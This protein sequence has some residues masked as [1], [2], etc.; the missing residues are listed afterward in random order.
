MKKLV[1]FSLKSFIGPF[2]ITLIIAMF[3]LI[4]QFFWVYIDDLLGKGLSVWV[5]LELLF[6]VSA[7]LIPLALPLSILLSSL[8]TFGNFSE[9]NE[10]TALKSSGFSLL[11][12]MRPL[13]MIV[14]LIAVSTFYFSNF[15]IPVANLKWH[16]LIYDIQNTKLSKLITPGVYTHE[17]DGY[18][19]KVHEDK[20]G[21]YSNIIIHDHTDPKALK[22]I[23]AKKAEI[24]RSENGNYLFFDLHQGTI[25]EETSLENPEI[26]PLQETSSN[27]PDRVSSFQRATYRM[28]VTGISLK[29][30]DEEVFQDK[31]EMLNVFQIGKA[32]DSLHRRI[33]QISTQFTQSILGSFATFHR[34]SGGKLSKAQNYDPMILGPTKHI[35]PY[36]SLSPS[37]VQKLRQDVTSK[38]YQINENIRN[39]EQFLTTLDHENSQYWIE[40]HRKFALT[41]TIVVLFFVGAPLGAVV[42]K[43]GF[44]APVVI[45]A[46]LFMLYFIIY[47][48]GDNLADTYSVSP[49]LGMWLPCIFFTPVAI[50]VSLL[51]NRDGSIQG[52]KPA[53]FKRWIKR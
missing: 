41:F 51:A 29:R 22:T 7:S 52:I 10:L 2:I 50:L 8:M 30:S 16:S 24:Y 47:S 5:I 31:Y 25:F 28:N 12:I 46:L 48:I 43:G 11:R 23:K 4:M 14:M 15:I 36:D 17:I 34:S 33:D 40:F 45:A 1:L 18:T 37:D 26:R 39:Q 49:W 21:G 9:N 20:S 6:Y 3:I 13:T 44:G 27:H 38:L 32:S 42:R 35:I 19:L 53:I